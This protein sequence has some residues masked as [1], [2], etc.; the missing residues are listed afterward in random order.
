M[1]SGEASLGEILAYFQEN[2][3]PLDEV[4]T[5]AGRIFTTYRGRNVV[6]EVEVCLNLEWKLLQLTLLLPEMAPPRRLAEAM[7]VLNR[8]NYKLPLGHFEIGPEDRQLAYYV[9]VPLNDQMEV[10]LLFETLLAWAVD[11]ADQEHPRLMQA[12]YA[13]GGADEAAL[14]E[15]NEPPRRYDA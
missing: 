5:A 2:E 1:I 4:D 9:A 6:M 14:E 10:G 3:W 8:I 15:L 12:I 11:I 7:G 13:G